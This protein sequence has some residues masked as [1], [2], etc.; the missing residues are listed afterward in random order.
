MEH[1][2]P[3]G[4]PHVLLDV[5]LRVVYPPHLFA[6]IL[7]SLPMLLELPGLSQQ[8]PLLLFLLPMVVAE[9]ARDPFPS[10]RSPPV[11]PSVSLSFSSSHASTP[12]P[13]RTHHGPMAIRM[14]PLH[15]LLL[16]VAKGI[17][18]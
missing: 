8:Y 15:P 12:P 4:Q 14:V 16:S 2:P 5:V 1:I 11:P 7:S 13:N 6:V 17:Y 10:S 9:G 3:L 18:P